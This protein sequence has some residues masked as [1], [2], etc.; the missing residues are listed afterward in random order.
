MRP[1]SVS[2]GVVAADVTQVLGEIL[3]VAYRAG[4][5]ICNTQPSLTEANLTLHSP[6][7]CL[8]ILVKSQPTAR[9]SILLG[10][11]LKQVDHTVLCVPQRINHESFC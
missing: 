7:S 5:G 9:G 8:L 4:G 6:G 3:E 1:F 11:S 10:P 2:A